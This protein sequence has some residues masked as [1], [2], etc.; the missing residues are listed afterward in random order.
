MA[1]FRIMM[2]SKIQSAVIKKLRLNYQGSIGIDGKLMAAADI[3]PGEKLQVLNLSSGARFE[4]YCIEEKAG[5]GMVCL[6]GPAARLGKINE[7]VF[8]ISYVICPDEEA[9]KIKP[10]IVLVD[11]QNRII[12]SGSRD[13][14]NG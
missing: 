8:I 4:T 10:R 2:K 5:S 1:M 14:A 6:Y 11:E 7:K 9:A 12:T 3:L 13:K